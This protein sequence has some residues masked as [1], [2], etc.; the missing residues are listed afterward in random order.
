MVKSEWSYGDIERLIDK[1]TAVLPPYVRLPPR[2][3]AAEEERGATGAA[4]R[5]RTR[6]FF[7]SVTKGGKGGQRAALEGLAGST[8]TDWVDLYA[9]DPAREVSLRWIDEVTT[10]PFRKLDTLEKVRTAPFFPHPLGCSAP[11]DLRH[12]LRVTSRRVPLPK[13]YVTPSVS[14]S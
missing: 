1:A 13:S 12:A 7:D 3:A 4:E 14:F 9:K 8:G 11:E 6:E 2:A 5:K 10:V